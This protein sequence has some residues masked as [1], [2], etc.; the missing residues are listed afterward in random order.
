MLFNFGEGQ[1]YSN[2]HLTIRMVKFKLNSIFNTSGRDFS[3]SGEVLEGT[4][5]TG[6]II[7]LRYFGVNRAILI[8]GVESVLPSGNDKPKEEMV[9]KVLQ[10]TDTDNEFLNQVIAFEGILPIEKPN[11]DLI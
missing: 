9:I 10:L 2:R 6:D 8:D 11:P 7:D 4:V 5:E 3:L 1:I